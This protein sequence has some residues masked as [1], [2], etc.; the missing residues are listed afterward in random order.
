MNSDDIKIAQEDQDLLFSILGGMV[1]Y[2]LDSGIPLDT[3]LACTWLFLMTL[4]ARDAPAADI[5]A[6]RTEI[7]D[8]IKNGK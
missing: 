1:R 4:Q 5:S 8:H 6:L 7:L 2:A 3:I